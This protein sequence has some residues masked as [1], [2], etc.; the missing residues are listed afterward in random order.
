[1]SH[2][3]LLELCRILLYNSNTDSLNRNVI[4][5]RNVYQLLFRRECEISVNNR[6]VES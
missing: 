5:Q 3:Q 2:V 1:M 6:I 4:P